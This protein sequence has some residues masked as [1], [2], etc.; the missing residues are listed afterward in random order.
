MN[1]VDRLFGIL[2]LLQAKKFVTVEKI[3]EKY[4]LSERTVYRDL[5]ALGELG[6]P[7]L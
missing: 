7:I 3:A 5:K 6:I 1:R 2:N 4:E